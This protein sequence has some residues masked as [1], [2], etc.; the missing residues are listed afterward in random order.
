MS[1]CPSHAC[2][3]SCT[4]TSKPCE[5][6]GNFRACQRDLARKLESKIEIVLTNWSLLRLL[7]RPAVRPR[8][9]CASFTSREPPRACRKGSSRLFFFRGIRAPMNRDRSVQSPPPFPPLSSHGAP[10]LPHPSAP[11]SAHSRP[12]GAPGH[13]NPISHSPHPPLPVANGEAHQNGRPRS[14]M[15]TASNA[16]QYSTPANSNP[17]PPPLSVGTGGPPQQGPSVL[18]ILA[19]GQERNHAADSMAHHPRIESLVKLGK[20]SELTW[21]QIGASSPRVR[22]E[23]R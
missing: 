3:L 14:S 1:I 23:C 17:P 22:L 9:A 6:L 18:Q 4:H 16:Q 11:S 15:D 8:H 12:N 13:V 20:E 2:C 21:L 5:I 10:R 19:M 7:L